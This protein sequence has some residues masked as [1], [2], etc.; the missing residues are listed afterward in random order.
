M[1]SVN[2]GKVSLRMLSVC[3]K[4][5]KKVS[6]ELLNNSGLAFAVSICS[7]QIESYFSFKILQ[8]Q[9][10]LT[11]YHSIISSHHHSIHVESLQNNC[12]ISY[13]KDKVGHIPGPESFVVPG[14]TVILT[15]HC[16]QSEMKWGRG[17]P[18]ST[19]IVVQYKF[20]FHFCLGFKWFLGQWPF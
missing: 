11:F 13:N 4:E 2:R 10:T 7:G 20:T 14:E 8:G 15:N 3:S 12:W 9:R 17:S 5:D 6:I 18:I 16:L 1:E 19:F